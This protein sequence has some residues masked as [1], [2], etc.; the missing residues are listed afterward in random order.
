[1]ALLSSRGHT[2]P[3][4]N[5]LA[6]RTVK[7]NLKPNANHSNLNLGLNSW[8]AITLDLKIVR[9]FVLFISRSFL[10]SA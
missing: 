2:E 3:N 8:L 1:M 4:V 6:Q 9:R 7:V 10:L 5:Y